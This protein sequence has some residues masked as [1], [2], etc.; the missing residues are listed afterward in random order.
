MDSPNRSVPG[1][2]FG[3]HS[4]RNFTV[5]ITNVNVMIKILSSVGVTIRRGLDWIFG[6]IALINSNR[7]YK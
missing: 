3:L 6:F 2:V 4:T 5:T 1:K 7:N